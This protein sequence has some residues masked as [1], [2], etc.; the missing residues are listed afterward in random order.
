MSI[1]GDST[2]TAYARGYAA[3]IADFSR[4]PIPD[5]RRALISSVK[6]LGSSAHNDQALE[7]F[8]GRIDA[9]CDLLV[10]RGYQSEWP[11]L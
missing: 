7:Y 2:A 4:Q 10:A 8:Q 11:A 5:L 3:G 1:L 6:L 9:A